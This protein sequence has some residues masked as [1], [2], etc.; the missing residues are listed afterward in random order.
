[1]Q[2]RFVVVCFVAGIACFICSVLTPHIL[3]LFDRLLEVQMYVFG[4]AGVMFFSF[5][6]WCTKLM[7]FPGEKSLLCPGC[8]YNL[9]GGEVIC[10]E[11]GKK[12]KI[13]DLV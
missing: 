12:S 4:V 8:R 7:L 13:A 11:C 2:K 1:M 10:S 6:L 5:G 9:C 3:R